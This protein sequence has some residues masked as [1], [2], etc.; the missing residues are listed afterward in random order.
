MENDALN[1]FFRILSFLFG[2][3]YFF[4]PILIVIFLI[5]N[6][7]FVDL[8]VLALLLSSGMFQ[9]LGLAFILKYTIKRRRPYDVL[10]EVNR[11][12]KHRD[13]SFP[14]NHTENLMVFSMILL[15]FNGGQFFI[16]GIIFIIMTSLVGYSRI[17]LGVH[18]PS[19]VI[20]G[21]FIGLVVG[22]IIA[23]FGPPFVYV[24]MAHLWII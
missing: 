9:N 17:H 23:I 2:K 4:I 10:D 3:I 22:L 11:R 15:L 14:S 20:A 21:F 16:W 6:Y 19:D 13:Y 7:F 18:Y 5:G 12:G 8:K 24:A 1:M